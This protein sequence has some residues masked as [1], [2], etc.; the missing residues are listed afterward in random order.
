[1][2]WSVDFSDTAKKQLKKIDR[3]WQGKILD[4][5]EDEVATLNN[6][7]EKGKA[8]V[9]DKKGLW[10]YRVGDYRILCQLIDEE[11]V[12]LTVIV[13]HRKNVYLD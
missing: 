2:A 10:R 9:G 8:L 1:M 3:K 5:L 4:Y 6:P 13:G 12:I 11:F 7:Q